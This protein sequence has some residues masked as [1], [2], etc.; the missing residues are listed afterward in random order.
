[1]ER[2]LCSVKT[3]FAW[4]A[5]R[6]RSDSEEGKVS[7]RI[8]LLGRRVVLCRRSLFRSGGADRR[9]FILRR[10]VKSIFLELGVVAADQIEGDL[11]LRG[12]AVKKIFVLAWSVVLHHRS[13]VTAI[14][15]SNLRRRF[16]TTREE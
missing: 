15:L 13:F 1:M 8:L 12:K 16:Q 4:G 11:F 3:S 10:A 6:G 5:D 14:L 9:N 7:K 2:E